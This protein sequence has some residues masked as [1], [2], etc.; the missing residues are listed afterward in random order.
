MNQFCCKVYGF[1]F[2]TEFQFKI[3]TS[4]QKISLHRSNSCY[5][6]EVVVNTYYITLLKGKGFRVV[7]EAH[8][9]RCYR[10]TVERCAQVEHVVTVVQAERL[11][12]HLPTSDRSELVLGK[13][14]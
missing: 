2:A 11:T 13:A 12:G 4:F 8:S 5:V 10:R 6:I 9:G 7:H 14:I 1:V 3:L